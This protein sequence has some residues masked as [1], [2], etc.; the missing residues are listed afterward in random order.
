MNTLECIKTRH[1][2][3]KFKAD[4]V[5]RE[6]IDQ[7]LDAG[8]RAP[9]GGNTQLTHFMVITNQDVLQELV[10]LIQEE[11]GKMPITENTLPYMVNIIKMSAEGKFVFH[12]NAPVL[13]VL[14]S[15]ANYANNF[16]D[17]SC[18]MQNMMLACNEL[19]LGSCWVNQIRHLQDNERIQAK[20]RELGLSEDEKVY[21][22]LAIGYPDLPNGLNHGS[23]RE[24]EAKGYPVTYID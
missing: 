8:R 12:Y 4:Q 22:S 20:M 24:I 5:S 13:I 7:V 17:V 16:A 11:Y 10:T 3:R 15:K 19:D 9:S 21:A 18:A 23:R 6:L 2:T 1:S 14:A